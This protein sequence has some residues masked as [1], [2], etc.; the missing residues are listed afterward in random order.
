MTDAG[1]NAL[2]RTE[3]TRRSWPV[4]QTPESMNILNLSEKAEDTLD[5]N[6]VGYVYALRT[7]YSTLTDQTTANALI[8]ALL[9]LQPNF[10]TAGSIQANTLEFNPENGM[11]YHAWDQLRQI[12]LAGDASGNRWE[13]GVYADRLAYYNQASASIEAYLR[14]GELLDA[15]GGRLQPWR[16]RPGLVQIDDFTLFANPPSSNIYDD[17][18]KFY[19]EVVEFDLGGYLKGASGLTFRRESSA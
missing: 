2:A 10:I 16:A 19:M 1:A 13:F 7:K 5:L 9:A 14:N 17:P 15:S 12:V 3:L 18:R 8:A 4:I 11:G 6:F